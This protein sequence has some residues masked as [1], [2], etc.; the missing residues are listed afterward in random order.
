MIGSLS[1]KLILKQPPRLLIDV[2]GVGYEC[3]APMSTFYGLPA[4]GDKV[5]LHTHL[6]IRD[7]AH[8]LYAFATMAEK[9][10]FRHLIKVSGVGP[11]IALAI[12]SGIGVDEFWNSVRNGESLRL[13]KVPGIG[14]KSAERL[15]VEL[16]DKAG[17]IDSR[18]AMISAGQGIAASPLQEARSAL[19]AL[20]Y[21]PAE[22]QR[23]AD[24]AKGENLTAEEIIR[25]ALKHAAR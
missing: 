13:T 7:D 14:K 17:A 5:T 9:E 4:T 24:V 11:K 1:G 8:L 18:T 20:G 25:E 6:I 21:K 15:V 12:L 23:L 16:R 3:E 2:N 10:L 22:A 19:E